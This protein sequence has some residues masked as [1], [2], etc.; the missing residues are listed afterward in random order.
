[1]WNTKDYISISI[2]YE[3]CILFESGNFETLKSLFNYHHLFE[4]HDNILPLFILHLTIILLSYVL[5]F[6]C[7]I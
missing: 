7:E 2:L 3:Q 5:K 1:M 4:G 6:E